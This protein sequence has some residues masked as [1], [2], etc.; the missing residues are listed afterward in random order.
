[1]E[2]TQKDINGGDNPGAHREGD[3]KGVWTGGSLEGK[4]THKLGRKSE[5]IVIKASTT[6]P[7]VGETKKR[8]DRASSHKRA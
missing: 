3:A 5:S 6:K 1:L 8:S 4:N 2:G 7:E